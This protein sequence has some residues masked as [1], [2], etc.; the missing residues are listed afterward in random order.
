VQKYFDILALNGLHGIEG[1]R[2]EPVI[3]QNSDYG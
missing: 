1:Q 3:T 2:K